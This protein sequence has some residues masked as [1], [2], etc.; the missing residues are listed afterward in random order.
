MA[1][2]LF[3]FSKYAEQDSLCTRSL[4]EPRWKHG[5]SSKLR[6]LSA[7]LHSR[8]DPVGHTQLAGYW[9]YRSDWYA[10]VTEEAFWKEQLVY[11]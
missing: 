5:L 8:A 2:S 6:I 4:N 1:N 7:Q 11:S 10:I 3:E 9:E